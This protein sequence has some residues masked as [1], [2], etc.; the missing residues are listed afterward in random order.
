M[1]PA[2]MLTSGLAMTLPEQRQDERA[3]APS[4]V[5]PADM[6]RNT[7]RPGELSLRKQEELWT[8]RA[9]Y[10]DSRSKELDESAKRMDQL[11]KDAEPGRS[12]LEDK[13]DPRVRAAI[14]NMEKNLAAVRKALREAQEQLKKDKE[15]AAAKLKEVRKRLQDVE[16]D[17]K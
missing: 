16:D 13:S 6:L 4:K 8:K 15:E 9:E 3:F 10:L 7:R 2:L 17:D 1:F 12:N 11:A 14:E 5:V